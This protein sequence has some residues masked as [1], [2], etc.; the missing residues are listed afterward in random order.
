MINPSQK[1]QRQGS[2]RLRMAALF[3]FL[4][5]CSNATPY[6]VR[7]VRSAWRSTFNSAALRGQRITP[8]LLHPEDSAVPHSHPRGLA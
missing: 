8:P 4:Y 3:L 7:S 1:F 2:E 6:Q 5:M